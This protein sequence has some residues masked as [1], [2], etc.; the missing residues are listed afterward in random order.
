MLQINHQKMINNQI[1]ITQSRVGVLGITFKENC[2]DIRNTKVI[3]LI[4]ELKSWSIDVSVCDPWAN[5]EEVKKEYRI[6]LKEIK[7]L[8]NLDSL[9]VAVGHNEFRDLNISILRSMCSH[10]H[11]ILADLKS[12]YNKEEILQQGF[13]LFRL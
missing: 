4:D 2:P 9:I 12:I 10:K 6:D 13:T 3:D 5:A 8:Q 7:D 11:P 1:D